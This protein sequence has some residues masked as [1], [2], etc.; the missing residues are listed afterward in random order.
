MEKF[1]A[2]W[3]DPE[4]KEK[5]MEVAKDAAIVIGIGLAWP[6]LAQSW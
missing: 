6:Q 3:K 1:K 4:T 5:A 2:F